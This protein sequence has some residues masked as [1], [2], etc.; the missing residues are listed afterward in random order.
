MTPGERGH[1]RARGPRVVAAQLTLPGALEHHVGSGAARADAFVRRHRARYLGMARAIDPDRGSRSA[2]WQRLAWAILTA[3]ASYEATVE[4]LRRCAAYGYGDDPL[5]PRAL[6]G[7]PGMVPAKVG[8]LNALPRDAGVFRLL[9]EGRAPGEAWDAYRLR[10]RASVAGLALTKASY[11][12]GLLYPLEADV[13][14]LDTWVQKI[15]TWTT[16]FEWLSL[17]EY[18][19]VEGAVRAIAARR[20]VSTFVAQWAIWDMVRGTT[21]DQAVFGG[22][23]WGR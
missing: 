14:C 4:A 9:R 1:A 23:S 6:S 20:R 5:P 21:T 8:Y 2:V 7:I 11:A 17:D 18:R 15:F 3:N 22:S 16:A 12:A 19:R 13:A 10:L